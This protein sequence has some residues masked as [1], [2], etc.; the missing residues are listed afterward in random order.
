MFDAKWLEV[1]KVGGWQGLAF[2]L[3]GGILLFLSNTTFI[4]SIP[5]SVVTGAWIAMILGGCWALAALAEALSTEFNIIKYI[6][7]SFAQRKLGKVI[8]ASIPF[9]NEHERKII[10]YLLARNQQSFTC[11]ADGGYAKTLIGRGIV[12]ITVKRGFA[13]DPLDVPATIPDRVWRV[14]QA[15]KDKFPYE[16]NPRTDPSPWREP[17]ARIR[18]V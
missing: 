3:A 12:I 13:F 17:S 9:M 2:A 18:R 7:D 1:L 14:L 15:H 4:P 11:D 8:E 16:G 6:K 10:S 5:S